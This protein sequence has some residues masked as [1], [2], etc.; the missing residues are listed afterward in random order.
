MDYYYPEQFYTL[1][2]DNISLTHHINRRLRKALKRRFFALK[3]QGTLV[4]YKKR[5]K[6]SAKSKTPFS[7]KIYKYSA[8][9]RFKYKDISTCAH[10]SLE[11]F[12]RK[13]GE[14]RY[15]RIE[16]NPS[17]ISPRDMDKLISL[18]T[19]LLA[20]SMNS[21][22][23]E[24]NVT[25]VD[26]T[27]DIP[28]IRVGEL[29]MR[30][31]GF[32]NGKLHRD[33]WG[34]LL[35]TQL[36]TARKI[37]K[38]YDKKA[39]IEIKVKLC[40]NEPDVTRLEI[41]IKPNMLIPELKSLSNPFLDLKFY[42]TRIDPDDFD[43]EFIHLMQKEGLQTAFTDLRKRKLRSLQN[44]LTKYRTE[45]FDPQKIWEGLDDAI[46]FLKRFRYKNTFQKF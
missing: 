13:K 20:E 45:L 17:Y 11:P 9:L 32:N 42:T 16:F 46:A 38:L 44:K 2:I 18:L 25:R 37:V 33:P 4:N 30:G 15:F 23:E 12:R 39:E 21:F 6:V 22:Y 31:P 26:F 3:N 34:R 5:N 28:N 27:I 40:N 14:T 7:K 24:A 43:P 29:L 19:Y 1:F 36:G 41:R 10:L 35:T 8:E